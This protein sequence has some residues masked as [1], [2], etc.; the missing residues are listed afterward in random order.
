VADGYFGGKGVGSEVD[1]GLDWM[2]IGFDSDSNAGRK[3]LWMRIMERTSR[4]GD[5]VFL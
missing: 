1:V 2:G 4:R 5:R 3:C